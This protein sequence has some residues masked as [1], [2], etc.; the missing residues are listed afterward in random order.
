MQKLPV[1]DQSVMFCSNIDIVAIMS[2]IDS[3][4][5]FDQSAYT[6]D[7]DIGSVQPVL[8]LSNPSST[9]ITVQVTA[10]SNTATGEHSRIL[11]CTS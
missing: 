10:S 6:V 8:V 11:Q 7:E 9:D 4:I 5:T 3:T 2:F 1:F